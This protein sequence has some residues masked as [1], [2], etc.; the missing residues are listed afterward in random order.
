MNQEAAEERRKE[1]EEEEEE[2]AIH[3]P[4]DRTEVSALPIALQR[5]ISE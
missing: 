2:E 4:P 3:T 1:G 5:E